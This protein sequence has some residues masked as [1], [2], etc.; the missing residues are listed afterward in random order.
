MLAGGCFCGAV[1]YEAEG[2]PFQRTLCHCS[3]CRG[4]S[5]APCVAWFS[6]PRARFRFVRGEPT[7]FASS[8]QAVRS[9]CP[10]CGS[11]LTFA[12]DAYAG[13]IDVTI[14]TLDDPEALP[15]QDHTF[16]R[17][18]LGWVKLADGLPEYE[19]ARA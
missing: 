8:P 6:V 13:E 19:A 5:G 12:S 16:V 4:T 9:F 11:Q 18:R 7:R 3:M 1:R 17:S 10:R 15:P 14:C 2:T